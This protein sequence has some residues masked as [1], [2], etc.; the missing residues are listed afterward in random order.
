M[1]FTIVKQNGE[2]EKI[3]LSRNKNIEDARLFLLACGMMT[4]EDELIEGWL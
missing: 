1:S 3:I 2:W 4:E